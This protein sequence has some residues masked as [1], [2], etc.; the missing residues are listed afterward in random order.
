ML[1]A[2]SRALVASVVFLGLSQNIAYAE[3]PEHP[4]T[5]VVPIAPGGG[6]DI[7]ARALSKELST[8]MGQPVIVENKP[9]AGNVIGIRNVVDAPAD[10]Y[11]LLFTSNTI[12]IDQSVK[13]HPEFDVLRD[14]Q[15]ISNVVNGIYA[16]VVSQDVPAH[17]LK[18]F[19]EYAKANPGKI[20]YGSTG[21]ATTGHLVTEE[22]ARVT[23]TSLFHVP[24]SGVAPATTALLSGDIQMLWGDVLLSMPAVKSGKARILAVASAKRSA[25]APDVPTVSES[26]YPGFE[27]DFKF[28][29]YAPRDTPQPIIDKLHREVIA[30][31]KSDSIQRIAAE[32]GWQLDGN[33]PS[34][35]R[36]MLNRE[37][38][39]WGRIVREAGIERR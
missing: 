35:F 16:L 3:Y 30:A 26:G 1:E 13:I 39:F 4:I 6:T 14:L 33:S 18:E 32:R 24:Y 27:A 22:F 36:A 11:R 2:L 34:E 7:F 31:L 9:G 17:N 29:L 37:I 21:P 20:N 5:V 15:P 8:Q 12:T 28:G 25:I 19:I 38:D 10:G 23:G